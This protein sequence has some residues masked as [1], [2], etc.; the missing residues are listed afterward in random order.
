M[1][2]VLHPPVLLSVLLDG[3]VAAPALPVRGLV[4]DSRQVGEGDVF[5][6]LKGLQ[7]DGHAYLAEAA[8]AGAVAALVEQDQSG[9][10]EGLPLIVVPALRPQL[11]RIASR[12]YGHPTRRMHVAAVTG[13]NGKTTV[14]QLFAQLV[15]RC[16]YDCGVIGTLGATLDGAAE[17]S[18]HTTPDTLALQ[19]IF[20]EWASQAVPFA[21]MEASSHALD[22]WRLDGVAVDTA[23]FTNLTRD[24][25][26]YHGD[27]TTYGEAKGRLF[28]F[29]ELRAAVI[30]GDDPYAARLL[31]T[32]DPA[33]K[34]CVY[35]T[36]EAADL[37]LEK[38]EQD[39]RGLS[40]MLRGPWGRRRVRTP[41][42]GDFNAM[43]V[44]AALAAAIEAGLPTD[45]LFDALP[46][47]SAVPGRMEPLRRDGAPLVVIDYAHTP[48]ALAKVLAALRAQCSGELVAVFGCGGDRDRGKRALMGEA[49]SAAADR[50]VVTS[51][52]PRGE[53]PLKIIGDIEEGMIGAYR[54]CPDRAE[55]IALAI[56]S[57]RPGDCVVIAGKGHEDYQIVGD[58]VR[59]FSDSGVAREVLAGYDR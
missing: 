49:V 44:V 10:P 43:N 39:A 7:F 57:A 41:L 33:V 46:S 32:L 16:S 21:A 27:M 8:R 15:R 31:A 53:D 6:A 37:R 42:L 55:A 5:V 48:D 3:I 9:A 45:V 47:L 51:D 18:T 59:P 12:F 28:G 2:G 52:N 36:A 22:Q 38:L 26:D 35:G 4:T 50:A 14:S 1:N 56:S 19:A 40:F 24:H 20:A 13:T 58:E 11:G 17:A 54:V 25:L 34:P 29:P 23:I 30:N